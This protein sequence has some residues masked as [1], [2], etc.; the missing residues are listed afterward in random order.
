[1]EFMD[2]YK[3]HLRILANE[4]TSFLNFADWSLEWVQVKMA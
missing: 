2:C 3:A 1:M 4:A